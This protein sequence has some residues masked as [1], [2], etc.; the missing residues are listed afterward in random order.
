VNLVGPTPATAEK[1][2]RTLAN[3]LKRPYWLPAP[4]WA[5]IAALADAGREL[6]LSDQRVV[7]QRLLDD[8]FTFRDATAEGAVTASVRQPS[9]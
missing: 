7:A 4:R 9:E 1:I 5:L 3:E 6:L 8:G 2:G